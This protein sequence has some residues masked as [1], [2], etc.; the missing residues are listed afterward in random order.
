M[1]RSTRVLGTTFAVAALTVTIAPTASANHRDG[2]R[3]RRG[4][5]TVC[6]SD[7]NGRDVDV[8]LRGNG[9][10]RDRDVNRC[11][12]FSNLR[13]GSYRV[14]LDAPRRCDDDSSRVY[15]SRGEREFVRLDAN[16]PDRRRNGGGGW[17]N[18]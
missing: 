14:S 16:C 17:W 7:T 2:D 8:E 9:V 6:V 4:S 12:T 3:D 10:N 5:I 1:R 11:T 15:L 13:S 18:N